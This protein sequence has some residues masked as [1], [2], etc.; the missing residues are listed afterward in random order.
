[1][2]LTARILAVA[3]VFDALRAKRPYRDAL[4]LEKVFSI[5][6]E[7]SPKALDRPCLEAL[8]ASESNQRFYGT[9]PRSIKAER[10]SNKTES[11][12]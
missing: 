12:V 1:L 4:P 3:D 2:T 7:D 6:R 9:V 11:P 10:V 8:I 5:M